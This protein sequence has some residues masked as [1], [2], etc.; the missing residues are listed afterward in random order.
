MRS[1]RV[2]GTTPD[3]ISA[4][5]WTPRYNR[6]KLTEVDPGEKKQNVQ[7][8]NSSHLKMEILG[9]ISSPRSNVVVCNRTFTLGRNA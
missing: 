9:P 1:M 7:L 4:G 8:I 3:T 6:E 5:L 2:P